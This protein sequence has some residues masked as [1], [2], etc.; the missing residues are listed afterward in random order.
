MGMMGQGKYNP[1]GQ[2]LS[3][4]IDSQWPSNRKDSLP[5][6]HKNIL[7]VK[8]F[9]IKVKNEFSLV[10]KICVII[11]K[12]AEDGVTEKTDWNHDKI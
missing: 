8:T 9:T 5:S 12:T 6:S 1:I 4:R 10:L 3:S 7:R 2:N 11:T